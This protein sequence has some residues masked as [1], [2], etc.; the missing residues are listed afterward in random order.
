[1]ENNNKYPLMNR[2]IIF[3]ITL[4]LIIVIGGSMAFVFSMQQITRTNKGVELS[5]TLEV[6]RIR[7]ETSVNSE[8]A[9]ALK[10]SDSPIVIRYFLNPSDPEL[11]KLA[12]EEIASYRRAFSANSVFWVND[13]D[14]FFYSDDNEP[15]WVNADDPENYWYNMT[16]HETEVYNF[17]INYNPD[18][19]II[20]LWINVPVYNDAREPIGIVGTG[21]GLSAFIDMVFKYVEDQTELYFFNDSGEIYGAKDIELV[22][23]K[24][25]IADKLPDID[26]D[27][28]SAAKSLNPGETKVFDVPKGKIAIGTI[29]S[30]KWYSLAFM[31]DSLSDYDTAMT[32]LFLVVLALISLIFVI[33]NLFIAKYLRSLRDT[34]ESLEDAKDEAEASTRYKSEF[35]AKMSHEIRTP[36]NAVLGVTQIYLQ[37]EDVPAEYTEAL[38]RIYNSGNNLLG[39]INDILD[40]SKIETGKLELNPV[41]YDIPSL[42]NDAAQFNIIRIGAKQVKFEL[43]VANTLPSKLYGD[44]LRLKQILNNLLSNAIKYTEKGQVK[45]SVNSWPEGED[46]I[47]CF[48]VEDTGQGLK[49]EDL[50]RMFTE[51]TRFNAMANRA[52][53]GTGL[54]LSIVKK[55]VELMDGTIKVES[56]YGKGS[57][58]TV[59]A[60]QKV[61]EN[62]VIGEEVVESLRGFDYTDDQRKERRKVVRDIMPYGRV[63]VVDDVETNLYVAKGLLAPYKLQVETVLSGFEAIEKVESGNTYDIIFM[64]HMM[65]EMDGIE[66]TQKMRELGYDGVIVALTANALVGND[67]MF[68]SKGFDDFVSKPINVRY[69][70]VVLNKFV[71]SRHP[72][73]AVKNNLIKER[74]SG[75]RRSG[76]RRSGDRRSK[77]RRSGNSEIFKPEAAI[78]DE[79]PEINAKLLQVFSRDAINAIVTFRETAAIGDIKLFTI[80]AHAMKSALANVGE[81]EMSSQALA[82][83]VAGTKGDTDYISANMESFIGT[84]ESLIKKI[85]PKKDTDEENDVVAEE[86]TE[87]LAEQ[88]KIVKAACEEYDDTTAYAALDQLKEKTW[89]PETAAMLDKFYDMLF[90]HSDFEGVAEAIGEKY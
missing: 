55:L 21:I 22:S 48:T 90:L 36:L 26:I 27:I 43:E 8:I 50:R 88:L 66:T 63:L 11:E 84:L 59:T 45:L 13:K 64:D 61:V 53:E 67:E 18:L 12:F 24:V 20:R 56:E 62:T 86:E 10:L 87:Y 9:I 79:K 38:E 51:Y 89:K 14:R 37:K 81:S 29:P 30:L 73:E 15:Y 2:F 52:T 65:P 41:V 49:P 82:L 17:N 6:E 60:K 42:I 46:I 34:M 25:S 1:M 77:D 19:K 5:Q 85:S 47:L 68:T 74:R 75:E 57:I 7:L 40:L 16:L 72:E 28:L 78:E 76:D 4:F 3:S 44:D 71:S 23:N 54:G 58:F 32:M 35:L 80:T 39:I 69:L 31:A 70:N 33:F 83:E